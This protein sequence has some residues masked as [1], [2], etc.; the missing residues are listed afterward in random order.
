GVA[1]RSRALETAER[2][3]IPGEIISLARSYLSQG[4]SEFERMLSKL[5]TDVEEA[6]RAKKEAVAVREEA[7]R[8]KKE[9]TQRTEASIKEV[10][11]RVKIRLRRVTEQ[12][13]D[14]VRGLVRK[15]DEMKNRRDL[16]QAR[17]K[18]GDVMKQA[19]ESIDQAFKEEAPELAERVAIKEN[20]P[21]T[22]LP[23]KENKLSVGASVRIPKWKTTGTILE[24]NGQKVKV[25][26]GTLQMTL[27]DSEVDWIPGG[28][29]S[30]TARVKVNSAS[31]DVPV[32][33]E[34]LDLR[35]IRFEEAMAL[36]EKYLDQAYRSGGRQEVTIVHGLGTGAI[37]EGTHQLLGRLPYVKSFRDGGA[38][39]GGSGATVVEFDLT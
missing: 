20:S 24:I 4:H 31:I 2:L 13:Q 30:S 15:L 12:A 1:G 11:D 10:M 32:P 33:L 35:G 19:S 34:K 6:A 17:G 39:H 25:A 23:A 28:A 22:V 38:G 26:M 9:W 21:E 8:L 14:E 18:I 36:L 37:R 29:K 3:G 5:Q 7:E 27:N 16:D